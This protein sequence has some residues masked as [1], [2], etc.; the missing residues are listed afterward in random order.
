MSEHAPKLQ[1]L[2]NTVH[3]QGIVSIQSE[4]YHRVWTVPLYSA[5]PA[6]K[7]GEAQPQVVLECM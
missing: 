2:R 7:S 3:V 1:E 6:T 4:T 5:A